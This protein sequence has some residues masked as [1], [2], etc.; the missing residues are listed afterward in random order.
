MKRKQIRILIIVAATAAILC[1]LLIFGFFMCA[2]FLMQPEPIKIALPEAS[3]AVPT[4]TANTATVEINS[5][6]TIALTV[7]GPDSLQ[8]DNS[9]LEAWLRSL[10]KI[11]NGDIPIVIK[12]SPDTPYDTVVSIIDI[13]N[14]HGIKRFS[15]GTTLR[16]TQDE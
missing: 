13:M 11:E 1:P 9:N 7:T 15:L 2:S 10:Q 4:A 14:I 12:A 3:E 16:E 8:A 5:D 6:G